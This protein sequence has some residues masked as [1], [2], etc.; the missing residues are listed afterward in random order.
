MLSTNSDRGRQKDL[1][2]LRENIEIPV[3][4]RVWPDTAQEWGKI[5][6]LPTPQEIIAQTVGTR[7]SAVDQR[8][9]AADI[10]GMFRSAATLP[11]RATKSI[12][13]P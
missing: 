3:T 5:A 4:Q 2:P 1:R 11:N 10:G 7:S 8:E 6:E 9:L 13:L 12:P